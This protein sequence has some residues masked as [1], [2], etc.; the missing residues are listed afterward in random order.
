MINIQAIPALEPVRGIWKKLSKEFIYIGI[1][2]VLS[3]LLSAICVWN[4]A[5]MCGPW[6]L[7]VSGVV[8]NFSALVVLLGNLAHTTNLV[9]E[10]KIAKTPEEKGDIL[11]ASTL[12][13]VSAVLAGSIIL[14]LVVW[15]TG[16]LKSNS[17][18][19]LYLIPLSLIKATD[20]LWLFQAFDRQVAQS[21]IAILNPLTILGISLLLLRP[22]SN[23]GMDVAITLAAASI[24]H[25]LSWVV[26]HRS[27]I[28]LRF[29]IL[30]NRLRLVKELVTKS[31]WLFISGLAGYLYLMFEEQ[32]IGFMVSIPELGKYRAAKYLSDGFGVLVAI[33]ANL[34]FPRYIEW[35]RADPLN[36]YKKIQNLAFVFLV[37]SGAANI[38]I[39]AGAPIF[40]RVVFGP[41]YASASMTCAVLLSAKS[42]TLV[43]N[44]LAWGLLADPDRYRHVA[45]IMMASAVISICL[46][47]TLLPWLGIIGGA[48]SQCCAETFNLCCYWRS[49]QKMIRNTPQQMA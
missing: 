14:C 24:I 48:I 41:K 28:P 13:R 3:I 38:L 47:I 1:S 49:A 15:L 21:W 30:G 6:K 22:T 25:A 10:F 39:Y 2:R 40:F 35:R 4:F 26:I 32:L 31:R 16:Y 9:Y 33:T 29:S 8:V 43:S 11:I 34:M 5:K 37:L 19:I 23:V 46:N 18:V 45:F 44:I 36:Y 12:I 20:A 7:G 42:I 17:P 27:C